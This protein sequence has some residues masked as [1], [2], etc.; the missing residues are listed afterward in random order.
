[1][2]DALSLPHIATLTDVRTYI[3]TK[4]ALPEFGD[5]IFDEIAATGWSSP[6]LWKIE[7][8]LLE[9]LE[10]KKAKKKSDK[11]LNALRALIRAASWRTHD[12]E[13]HLA[14]SRQAHVRWNK[15]LANGSD[16]KQEKEM[17]KL[18]EIIDQEKTGEK[19]KSTVE[20][21]ETNLQSLRRNLDQELEQTNVEWHDITRTLLAI[22]MRPLKDGEKIETILTEIKQLR[23]LRDQIYFQY[24]YSEWFENNKA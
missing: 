15:L 13:D 3:R 16:K 2:S 21:I 7:Q 11:E 4:Y 12:R 20:L 23:P 10:E 14:L 8:I 9:E 22:P 24:L 19:I 1:M 6:S 5:A 17:K 18:C